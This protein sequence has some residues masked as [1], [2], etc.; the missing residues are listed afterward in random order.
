MRRY[1][2]LDETRQVVGVSTRR[3]SNPMAAPGTRMSSF[4]SRNLLL[5]V[6]SVLAVHPTQLL[7]AQTPGPVGNV[8]G[9]VY[10]S[11]SKK[12]LSRAT[13]RIQGTQLETLAD[14]EGRFSF[15]GVPVGRQVFTFAAPTLDN[16]GLRSA[17]VPLE[18]TAGQTAFVNLAT[19]SLR[20]LWQVL[21]T[22]R[23]RLSLDSG[24]V[25]GTVVDGDRN[26]RLR[27][28][29][30]ALSWFNL[31]VPDQYDMF[32][33][34]RAQVETDSLGAYIACGVPTDVS[35]KAKA[36]G[37]DAS[38]GEVKYFVGPHFIRR[39]DMIVTKALASAAVARGTAT[40]RGTVRDSSGRPVADAIVAVP[41]ADTSIRTGADGSFVLRG[42]AAG[43]QGLEVRKVGF[44]MA[45]PQVNLRNDQEA[46]ANVVMS[47]I[48]MLDTYA[49]RGEHKVTVR[50]QEYLDR[51]KLGLGIVI[52]PAKRAAADP[53]ALLTNVPRLVVKK[54]RIGTA[55]TIVITRARDQCTPGMYLDGS[56]VD[57]ETM[58]TYPVDRI[59]SVEVFNSGYTLP[60]QFIK[61]AVDPCGAIVYW[62]KTA[63]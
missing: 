48:T 15:Q 50:E 26:L 24:I 23:P 46:V 6:A 2:G 41:A 21:C 39:V 27:K 57:A 13:V 37:D 12:P 54:G 30:T 59:R 17:G 62:T 61:T 63:W 32:P 45:T 43:S 18:I 28:A 49:V 8:S 11:L 53:I 22:G 34:V 10:D 42:L 56:P 7:T 44:G 20:R 55:D 9:L 25:T 3:S 14:A 19:P 31:K 47:G 60:I 36:F 35:I 29:P 5:V 52:D 51:R 1:L 16:S 4:F 33:E 58:R 40:L 38:T